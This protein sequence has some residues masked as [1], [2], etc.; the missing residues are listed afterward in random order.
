MTAATVPSCTP[1]GDDA[2]VPLLTVARTANVARGDLH[3]AAKRGQR[4]PIRLCN[5]PGRPAL[6]PKDEAIAALTAAALS[7]AS[8]IAFATALRAVLAGATFPLPT[9]PDVAT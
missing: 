2:L 7:L 1:W 6:I 5:K 4:H 9:P 8:G 3:K